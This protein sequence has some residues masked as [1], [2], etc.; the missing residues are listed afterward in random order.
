MQMHM[1]VG[2]GKI[3]HG[4]ISHMCAEG[5]VVAFA[6]CVLA[7]TWV[8]PMHICIFVVQT[9]CVV[10]SLIATPFECLFPILRTWLEFARGVG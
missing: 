6:S 3:M 2:G 8:S 9:M 1:I 4:S 5:G 7:N 10:V